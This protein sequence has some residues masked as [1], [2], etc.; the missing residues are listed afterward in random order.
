MKNLKEIKT[1]FLGLVFLAG[2]GVHW[3]MAGEK[4]NW[5]ALAILGASAVLLF[6]APD[7][8]IDIISKKSDKL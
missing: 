5:Y 1:T 3:Y 4:V 8:I 2:G 7:K 6:L